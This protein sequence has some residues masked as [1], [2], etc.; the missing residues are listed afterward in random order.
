M[1]LA[2]NGLANCPMAAA[3]VSQDGSFEYDKIVDGTGS[4]N[5]EG[6][7]EM[8][9]G[10]GRGGGGQWWDRVEGAR[11]RVYLKDADRVSSV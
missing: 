4:M 6:E 3:P 7:P 10:G 1:P 9:G 5:V 8:D 2:I 11:S